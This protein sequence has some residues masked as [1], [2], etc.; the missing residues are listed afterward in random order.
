MKRRMLGGIVVE[1][2]PAAVA[3]LLKQWMPIDQVA[4]LKAKKAKPCN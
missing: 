3:D 4:K 1:I 2:I